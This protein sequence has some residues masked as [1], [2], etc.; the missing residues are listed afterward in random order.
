[1]AE[2]EKKSIA[3]EGTTALVPTIDDAREPVFVLLAKRTYDIR[4]NE[5]PI[6]ADKPVPLAH[7]D[8]YY[9]GGDPD[10]TTVQYESEV[11]PFK[12]ATDVVVIGSAFAPGGR[13]VPQ[14][15]ASVE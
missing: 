13:R 7:V 5:A 12:L 1:M 10:T 2:A 3:P 11:A 14:L 8:R 6:P 9:E 15:D 4:P